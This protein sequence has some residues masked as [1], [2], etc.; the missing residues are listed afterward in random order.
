MHMYRD[1]VTESYNHIRGNSCN[2]FA[3][4]VAKGGVMN[5]CIVGATALVAIVAPASAADLP[6]LPA[7]APVY[8]APPARSPFTWAGFYLGGSVGGVWANDNITNLDGLDNQVCC[9]FAQTYSLKDTGIIGGG[10]LGYNFQYGQ[11]V[12][13]VEADL[14]GIGFGKTI[15]EPGAVGVTSNHLGSGFYSDVTARLG[16]TFDRALIYAKGGYAYFDG[17]A[18]V[19]NNGGLFGGGVVTT[20]SFDGGWTIGGGLEYALCSAWSAKIEY[21]HFDFGTKTALLVTPANGNFR[22]SN[23]LTAE[24]VKIGVN[25]HFWH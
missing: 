10:V 6:D 24:T 11:F 4:T 8:K 19:N 21:Q 9:G 3:I 14:G 13:G 17:Q 5:K 16:Y 7:K 25:Y 23:D 18:N 1:K 22:F 15:W 12:Y 20:G 2:C